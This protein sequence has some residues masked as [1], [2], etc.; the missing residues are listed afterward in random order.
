MKQLIITLCLALATT[1]ALANPPI[2]YEF[3]ELKEVRDFRKNNVNGWSAVNEQVL[4]VSAGA[5]RNYLLVLSRPDRDLLFSQA[6]AFTDTQ[7]RVSA[8]F[9]KVYATNSN[10]RMPNSIQKIYEVR[11]RDQ[12]KAARLAVHEQA[13]AQSEQDSRACRD[14]HKALEKIQ[15]EAPEENSSKEGQ[16]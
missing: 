15:K 5:S 2:N 11:G 10:I 16:S 1:G 7:G 14:Y 12:V 4:M 9:D 8:R 3:P 6:L 13:C